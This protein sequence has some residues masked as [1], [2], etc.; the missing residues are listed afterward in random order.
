LRC[1]EDCAAVLDQLA[2]GV[3]PTISTCKLVERVQRPRATSLGWWQKM[4][5]VAIACG[6]ALRGG[7][8]KAIFSVGKQTG[9][10]LASICPR[11]YCRAC[12]AVLL[13]LLSLRP[14]SELLPQSYCGRVCQRTAR[15]QHRRAANRRYQQAESGPPGPPTP[16]ACLPSAADQGPRD[17]SRSLFGHGVEASEF[18]RP[19]ELCCLRPE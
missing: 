5:E 11:R 15:Q 14:W 12:W 4:E 8:I 13:R 19:V 17:G 18:L 10:R 2:A 3:R 6:T 7:S 1:S 16:P 9:L